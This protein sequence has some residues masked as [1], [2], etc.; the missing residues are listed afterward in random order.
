MND[1]TGAILLGLTRWTIE[2]WC[3][4]EPWR[5]GGPGLDAEA[6][7]PIDGLFVTLK[8][9]LQLRGCIGTVDRQDS[10]D[11]TLRE[12]AVQAAGSDPRFPPLDADE[13]SA[14][15]I[16]LSLLTP[17]APLE[18]TNDIV[19]GRDG[20]ILEQGGRRGLLLPEVPAELGWDLAT[21]LDELCKKA[22]LPPGA[23]RD[24]DSKLL[25][26]ESLKFSETVER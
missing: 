16:S 6:D 11:A 22:F 4:G 12:M 7:R 24:A 3:A 9:G 21:Y 18:D 10:L 14:T 1:S 2:R 25:R 26:F 13:L 17:P 23:W 5:E 19:I 8:I 15:T 20:L